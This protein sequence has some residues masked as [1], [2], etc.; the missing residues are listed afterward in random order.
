MNRRVTNVHT[1]VVLARGRISLVICRT[2]ARLTARLMLPATATGARAPLT[3]S[4][5]THVIPSLLGADPMAFSGDNG[6]LINEFK[7]YQCAYTG[8]AC[9]WDNVSVPD[10]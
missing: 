7:G 4:A 5:S 6:V 10:G 9:T 1:Q 3:T 2:R 8:G